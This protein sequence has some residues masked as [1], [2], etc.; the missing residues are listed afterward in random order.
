MYRPCGVALV[1][2]ARRPACSAREGGPSRPSSR[3][4]HIALG[5]GDVR[6]AVERCV[7]RPGRRLLR[8]DWPWPWQQDIDGRVSCPRPRRST[9]MR[10]ERALLP[11][12]RSRMDAAQP[13]ATREARE[14]RQ[15]ERRECESKSTSSEYSTFPGHSLRFPQVASGNPD[16]GLQR[17][18]GRTS[19][20]EFFADVSGLSRVE[21]LQRGVG[22]AVP[23]LRDVPGQGFAGFIRG[24]AYSSPTSAGFR[25]GRHRRPRD[26]RVRPGSR[27]DRRRGRS[28]PRTAVPPSAP[29]RGRL[30]R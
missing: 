3:K 25:R 26:H 9:R 12:G 2:R 23:R 15:L 14:R 4:T 7:A 19:G 11:Q 30:R 20:V 10:S 17:E 13:C 24:N 22:I 28:M 1:R 29:S 5:S 21:E 16:P 8:A 18:M 6:G 27:R